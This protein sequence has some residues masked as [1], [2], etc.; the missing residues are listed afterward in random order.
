MALFHEIRARAAGAADHPAHRLDAPRD[1]GASWCSAGAADYVAKPWDDARLITTVRNL[2]DLRSAR[3][4]AEALRARAARGAAAL[5]ERFDLRGI[6]YESEAMH[7]LVAMATQV[8]HADVPVLITGP[9]GAGKEVLADIVQ[10]N[11]AQADS[12]LLQGQP[13]R[14]AAGADRG[15]AVRHRGRRLHRRAQHAPDASRRPTAARCFSMSSAPLGGSGQAKLLRVLQTGEFERLGSNQ[16]RR[17]RVRVIAATNT[18]AARGD[19]RRH[20]FARTCSI[21]STSSSSRCR[22][23][24]TRREDMLPLARHFLE[25]RLRTQRRRRGG[26]RALPLAGQRARAAERHPPRLPAVAARAP[27]APRPWHCRRRTPPRRRSRNRTAPASSRRSS[28]PRGVVAHAAR[29]LGLSRQALYRRM[30]RLGLKSETPR[31]AAAVMRPLVARRA[32][33]RRARR[34]RGRRGGAHGAR[35][36]LGLGAC[37]PRSSRCSRWHPS[38]FSPP[39]GSWLPGRASCARSATASS[40]CATTTSASRSPAPATRSSARSPRP[41]TALGELL[42]RERLDLYQRELL[43]DTVIQSSPLGMVL[44]NATGRIVYSNVAA[45]E[46]LHSG[47]KLEGL[48]FARCSPSS[49]RRPC[50]RRSAAA[51]DTLFTMDVGGRGA[52]VS[53]LAAAL[54]AQCP[55]APPAAAQAADAR[56][57][58]PGGRGLEEG[59]PRHRP[60]AQ[61]LPRADHLARPLRA[62]ARAGARRPRSSSACSRPS[63]SAPR[64]WLASSTAM[65]ASPSCRGRGRRRCRGRSFWRVWRARC[66]FT[67][68]ASAARARR[69]LRREPDR[70][71]D[72]QSAE[73]RRRVRLARREITVAISDEGPAFR[74]E[75]GDRGAGLS[76]DD[77]CATRCCPSTPPS[78]P[79]RASGSPYAARSSRRTAGG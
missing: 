5:A 8:A 42:R 2:L 44:T 29:D 69:Q 10:A 73:E 64:T 39:S 1:R 68:P 48:E 63:A 31:S 51:S 21:A 74:I 26:A 28:A 60:R 65:R 32:H 57:R 4:E 76:S 43:L 75:V 23:S 78:P 53:P 67:P 13:R 35:R 24:P 70:A 25:R 52:G 54:P 61:Q 46:L 7:T 9:N 3:A 20:A 19:A 33:R 45:R 27:S 36:A 22:R 15:G 12:P 6:V 50:A 77:A 40:A 49:P 16:T 14:A 71:G 17:T 55:P 34:Q 72:D 47:R 56:A 59:D 58:R 66:R 37:S 18:H 38:C 11:S 79:V 30:E 62:A 41:T